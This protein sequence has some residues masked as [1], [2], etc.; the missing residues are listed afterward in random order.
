MYVKQNMPCLEHCLKKLS[1]GLESFMVSACHELHQ[2]GSMFHEKLSMHGYSIQCHVHCGI[3]HCVYN[4]N[5][6]KFYN[7]SKPGKYHSMGNCCM[8]A[9]LVVARARAII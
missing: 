1:K 8:K 2:S 6:E 7:H 3:L 4:V 9:I 5:L